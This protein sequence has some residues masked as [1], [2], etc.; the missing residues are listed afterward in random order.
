[1]VLPT[2]L[3]QQIRNVITAIARRMEHRKTIPSNKHHL[4]IST[5]QNPFKSIF[6]DVFPFIQSKFTHVQM[7]TTNT[8]EKQSKITYSGM[9]WNVRIEKETDCQNSVMNSLISFLLKEKNVLNSSII[10]QQDLQDVHW[11]GGYLLGKANHLLLLN[12]TQC[13]SPNVTLT[14]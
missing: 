4:N 5:F 2:T 6:F 10:S 7:Y 9:Q 3:Q 14:G 8:T 1:M 11:S 13:Q 12:Q